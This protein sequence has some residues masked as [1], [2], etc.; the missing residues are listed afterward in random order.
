MVCKF[1]SASR[2]RLLGLTSIRLRIS[3]GW[4]SSWAPDGEVGEAVAA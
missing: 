1:T 2:L 4:A 3:Y